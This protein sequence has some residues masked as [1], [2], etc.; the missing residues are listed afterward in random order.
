MALFRHTA[1]G[2]F[3]GEIWTFN[4]HTIGALPVADANNAFAV[5]LQT[6]FDA[7]MLAL[8]APDVEVTSAA[9][10]SIDEATDKQIT[11]VEDALGL[12]GT[13]VNEQL[14]FNLALVVSL[15]TSLATR[16]GRGRFY[17]PAMASNVL[18]GGRL[19]TASQTTILN[20]V[21][22]FILTLSSAGLQ[23][24]VRNPQPVGENQLVNRVEVGDVFDQQTRRRN[25]L[26]EVRVGAAV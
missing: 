2:T 13:S 25:K 7:S 20:A 1:R 19:A 21:T 14:P 12:S 3:P 26:V 8:Y 16:A 18:A 10:A 5:G 6:L 11:R 15:R 22:G 23:T 24:V 9:T 4:I 17:L